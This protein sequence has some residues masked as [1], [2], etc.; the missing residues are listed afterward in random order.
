MAV[1]AVIAVVAHH[2]NLAGRH[3]D[4]FSALFERAKDTAAGTATSYVA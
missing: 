1:F 3:N 4:W 2:E